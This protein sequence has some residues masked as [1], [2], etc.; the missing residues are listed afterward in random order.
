MLIDKQGRRIEYLRMAVTDRCNLRCTYCMPENTTFVKKNLLLSFEE[1]DRVTRL[2]SA[3]GINKLRIT[4]GEPFA[5][6]QLPVLLSMLKK[7]G[8]LSRISITTNGV[9][10]GKY[11]DILE[12]LGIKDINLSLD[13][14]SKEKF[15]AI[16]RRDDFDNVMDTFNALLERKFR[17]KINCVV[18]EGINTDDIL[19]LAELA[20]NNPISIRFIEEMPF[21]GKGGRISKLIWDHTKILETIQNKYPDIAPLKQEPGKTAMVHEINGFQGNVGII[22]AYSRTFCGSCN[23]IRI[24]P[25]GQLKTCLYGHNSLDIRNLLRNGANDDEILTAIKHALMLR[26]ENGFEAEKL[27][28]SIDNNRITMSSIGG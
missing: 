12:S 14:L 26:T 21:N 4:G 7:N 20:K 9:L 25:Q 15:H 18:M 28:D 3:H 10:T 6:H 11:L 23:R 1:I 27:R 17:V 13:T 24:T 22:A 2:L 8:Q 5:R 16:T 19:P